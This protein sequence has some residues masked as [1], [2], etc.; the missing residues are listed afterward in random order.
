MPSARYI[1]MRQEI[2]RLRRTLIPRLKSGAIFAPTEQSTARAIAFRLMS[3][4]EIENYLEDCVVEVALAADNAWKTGRKVSESTLC[5]LAFS[6]QNFSKPP[7]TINSPSANQNKN[8]KQKLDPDHRLSKAITEFIRSVKLDNHG[9][10]E[11][12]ILAM[13]LPIGVSYTKIDGLLLT[14][15][16]DFAKKRGLSAHLGQKTYVTNEIN[17]FDELNQVDRILLGLESIDAEIGRIIKL[18]SK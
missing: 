7:E 4:A 18:I 1:Q 3:H 9:I 11:R 13:L 14:E 8:W 15:I 10:T 17:P 16:N 6:G 5:L 12:C 2:R